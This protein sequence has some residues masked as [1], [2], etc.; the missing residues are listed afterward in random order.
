M[1]ILSVIASSD[2]RALTQERTFNIG[3]LRV[4]VDITLMGGNSNEN[5]ETFSVSLI[6]SDGAVVLGRNVT[7]VTIGM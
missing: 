7:T 3:T 5:S 1:L 4:C 6:T 2:Y